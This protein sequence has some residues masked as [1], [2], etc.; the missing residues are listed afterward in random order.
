MSSLLRTCNNHRLSSLLGTHLFL[1]EISCTLAFYI[2][3][4]HTTIF[5]VTEMDNVSDDNSNDAGAVQNNASQSSPT[6]EA[7]DQDNTLQQ[8]QAGEIEQPPT[9]HPI[10]LPP[11]VVLSL[12]PAL[13]L[14]A[15]PPVTPANLLATLPAGLP[16]NRRRDPEATDR[17]HDAFFSRVTVWQR[18]YDHCVFVDCVLDHCTLLNCTVRSPTRVTGNVDIRD[19]RVV[20]GVVKDAHAV[21]SDFESVVL[22]NTVLESCRPVRCDILGTG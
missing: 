21:K 13:P 9:R 18:E 5:L 6:P 17:T 1:L 16:L 15:L 19:C 22:V 3:V 14:S 8:E 10:A 20:G 11:A 2:P 7:E 4:I 12:R